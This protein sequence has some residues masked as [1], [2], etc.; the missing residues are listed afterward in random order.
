L[1]EDIT[2]VNAGDVVKDMMGNILASA[3]AMVSEF[4]VYLV[5]GG[6]QARSAKV[7]DSTKETGISVYPNPVIGRATFSHPVLSY[8]TTAY[9]LS[10]SGQ[11]VK[12][13]VIP[14]GTS[15]TAF[16]LGTLP[17][18]VYIVHYFGKK[19]QVVKFIR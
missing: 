8:T 13:V 17:R 12:G 3:T 14:P 7:A 18:G 6:G 5:T 2:T 9:I 19:R 10:M 16:E 11:V 1:L 15:T 4:P